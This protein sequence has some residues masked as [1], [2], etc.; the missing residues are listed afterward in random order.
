L[1]TVMGDI[2]SELQTQ[3]AAN[4]NLEKDLEKSKVNLDKFYSL[5]ADIK[6]LRSTMETLIE[7]REKN[8]ISLEGVERKMESVDEGC[9]A[10]VSMFKEEIEAVESKLTKAH[11]EVRIV[12]AHI[13]HLSKTYFPQLRSSVAINSKE[14]EDTK[15]AG[16]VKRPVDKSFD[17][18]I[19]ESSS[20]KMSFANYSCSLQ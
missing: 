19:E 15:V 17:T 5:E 11:F 2:E 4:E 16:E 8:K 13:A 10:I 3:Q 7:D 1:Y 18:K 9:G 12:L 6:Q 14:T 20:I